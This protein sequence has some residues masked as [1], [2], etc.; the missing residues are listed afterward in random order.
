M[1]EHSHHITHHKPKEENTKKK[2][3]GRVLGP[4][5]SPH[6][7]SPSHIRERKEEVLG[8]SSWA[9]W[10]T[11]PHLTITHHKPKEENT[12]KKFLGRVLG[13]DGILDT[14][15]HHK[16]KE[17]NTKKKFLG[18]VLGP[19]VCVSTL[20]VSTMCE[21][22]T[23][24]STLTISHITSRKKRTQRRSSWAEF[25]GQMAHHT[26][27][28]HHKR[29]QRRSSWAEFLGRMAHHT[30]SHHHTS[31]AERREHKEEVLGPSSWAGGHSRHHHT[32]QAERRE[33]KEEV[34]GPSS[35]AGWLTTPHLTITHKRTQRRSSWAEFLGRM[36]HHTTSHHHTSQ[37]ERREH[38]EEV[39]GPSS[40]AGCMCEHSMCEHYV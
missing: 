27:S 8:P 24:V 5:G 32:S 1:C 31:Q 12:K 11:T 19:D 34:L 33:H 30:T 2:F 3:L 13:P 36:A 10:L 9:G 40:W 38:K 35:W 25:L 28:H 22:S 7:I 15:T 14:I 17:E 16:P 20:C 37:A 4:D 18:R 29:T 39:L 21:H 23:C 26:T 6:H